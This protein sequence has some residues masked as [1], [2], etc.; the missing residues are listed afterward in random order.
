MRTGKIGLRHHLYRR[1]VLEVANEKCG[2]GRGTQTIR[3]VLLTCHH[4]GE[5]RGEL[6]GRRSGG[7]NREGS[8]KTIL[9]TPKLVTRAAKF[10]LRSGLLGQ[11]EAVNRDEIS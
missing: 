6:F 10:M 1:G 9:N 5:L 2:C 11:F 8:I 4:F 3:H 7:P